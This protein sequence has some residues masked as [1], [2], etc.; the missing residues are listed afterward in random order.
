MLQG[1]ITAL[2]TPMTP[3]GQID[4]AT[5]ETLVEEQIKNGVAGLVVAGTTGES[6]LLT[7]EEL[8]ALI[9][10]VIKFN[11]NRIKIIVGVS[12]AATHA[13]CQFIE[14]Y[15]NKL[16]GIDYLL[17]LTPYYIK[18]TQDGMYEYFSA[19]SKISNFPIILYN[20]PSRTGV[21]L[22]NKTVIKL[23]HDIPTI[24]A[25]KDASGDLS[26]VEELKNETPTNFMLYSGDDATFFE[27]MLKGGDGVISVTSN[28]IPQKMSEISELTLSN[29]DENLV[30]AR[31][32]NESATIF[33]DLLFIE[34][35]PIPVK[36]SLFA[37]GK[38]KTPN[39]RSPLTVL[40]PENQ[41]KLAIALEQ[42]QG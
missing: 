5:L 23:A 27:F 8:D 4:F 36:W 7:D 10:A 29:K 32:L 20:V 41:Q 39:M 13:T 17:A 15:L 42:L 12:G 31:I 16:S 38:T 28:I 19:I 24:V 21:D 30:K 6:A 37:L 40:R 34:S 3:D 33:Y 26:R 11:Q 22:H 14:D 25:I 2:V 1:I 35:N 9:C 18:P